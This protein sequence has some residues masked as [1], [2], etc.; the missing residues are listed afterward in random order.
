MKLEDI[1]VIGMGVRIPGANDVKGYEKMLMEKKNVVTDIPEERIALAG[2]DPEGAYYKY[3]YLRDI[4][5]FDHSFFNI[6]KNEADSTD[7]EQKLSLELAEETFEDAGYSHAMLKNTRTAVILGVGDSR[8]EEVQSSDAAVSFIGNLNSFA[9]G[10]ISYFYGLKGP[11]FTVDSTCSSSLL[12]VHNAISSLQLD[13]ADMALAGGVTI[14]VKPLSKKVDDFLGISSPDGMTRVFDENSNG[15]GGGEGAGMV[16]LKRLPDALRDNDRIYAVIHSSYA[17]NDGNEGSNIAAPSYEAQSEAISASIKRSG[18]DPA[19]IGYYE[20]HGTATRIGDPIEIKG[21]TEAF[22]QFTDKRNYC[23]I[24]ASK[25]NL[26]HTGM[27]AGILG[28]IK[29]VS[30]VYNG[31]KYPICNFEKP[32]VLIDFASSPVYPCEK[33]EKWEDDRRIAAMNSFGFSGTNVNVIIENLRNDKESVPD[34]ETVYPFI[35]SGIDEKAFERNK[36][37]LIGYLS[38][39]P[40]LLRDISYTLSVRRTVF[41]AAAAVTAAS[42]GELKEKLEA[43]KLSREAAGSGK[44]V[45]I[46]VS[47]NTVTDNGICSESELR[48]CIEAVEWLR[49]SC[50]NVKAIFGSSCGNLVTSVVSGKISA[51]DAASKLSKYPDPFKVDKDKVTARLKDIINGGDCVF[52]EFGSHGVLGDIAEELG[53]TVIR[54]NYAEKAE[55]YEALFNAGADVELSGFYDGASVIS[56]PAYRFEDIRS[57]PAVRPFSGDSR[58]EIHEVRNY[59]SEEEMLEELWHELLPESDFTYDDDFFMVGGESLMIM[60]MI[61][62]I[63]ETYGVTLGFDDMDQYG[64]INELAELIRSRRAEVPEVTD[65]ADETVSVNNDDTPSR[66]SYEQSA[67]LTIYERDKFNS[68]YAM[69]SFLELKGNVDLDNVR[70]AFEEIIRNNRILHSV[71]VKKSGE[72][73]QQSVSP[74]RFVFRILREKNYDE[75]FRRLDR[76]SAEPFELYDDLPISCAAAECDDGRYFMLLKMHHIA[77]DIYSFGIIMH[78]FFEY[79]RQLS[80][81][82]KIISPIA[83]TCTYADYAEEQRRKLENN[84]DDMTFWREYLSGAPELIELPTIGERSGASG[85]A[86]YASLEID[87]EL[88]RMTLDYISGHKYSLYLFT[89]TLFNILLHRYTMKKDFCVG[90]T[91]L[92]RT[93]GAAEGMIGFF[94]N[95]LV[96][97]TRIGSEDSFHDVLENTRRDLHDILGHQEVPFEYLVSQLEPERDKYGNVYFRHM[98]TPPYEGGN[99]SDNGLTIDVLERHESEAKFDMMMFTSK[100][101]KG[102]IVLSVEYRSD[103][104][105]ENYIDMFLGNYKD[106]LRILINSDDISIDSAEFESKDEE[107]DLDYDF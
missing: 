76:I 17:N 18:I 39:T 82:G 23:A 53:G 26:G 42:C 40:A 103:L 25:S 31:V 46:C 49:K 30:A 81:N 80:E 44:N 55:A 102:N 87:E 93:S 12:A 38:G 61:N 64:S 88:S 58:E 66:V 21:I 52:A 77:G 50:C 89:L 56:L 41:G 57:W 14:N 75:I 94:A 101:E 4:D 73:F 65:P 35:V 34:K 20:A 79:Y 1:A 96:L 6:N 11:S 74:D 85:K 16:L 24:S 99:M 91:S 98:F 33:T 62:R 83:E 5:K 3:G 71:Y 29:L 90:I 9:A 69:N 7:P 45:I 22:R 107:E 106:M 104:Y 54:L 10:R 63:K 86:G 28:F 15:T 13:E 19:D 51:E 67:M 60:K 47:G 2:A 36:K 97:R 8:F 32:N 43:L 59:A 72:F 37:A 92:N 84:S 95:T 48:Y 105:D 70:L 78:Q 100:N 68:A 27:A